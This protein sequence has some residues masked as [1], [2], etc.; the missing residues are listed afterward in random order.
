MPVQGVSSGKGRSRRSLL[1][2]LEDRVMLSVTLPDMTGVAAPASNPALPASFDVFVPPV[3][4]ATPSAS[5]PK[6]AQWTA[7]GNPDD[8]LA[9]SGKSLSALTGSS[10]GAD[11]QFYSYGQTTSSNGVLAADTIQSNDG[12]KAAVTLSMNN[13]PDSVYLLW[14]KNSYGYSSP[15]AINKATTWWVGPSQTSAG[16]TVSVYGQNLSHDGGTTS[17]WIYITQAGSSNGQWATVTSVNPYQVQFTV[18]SNLANGNYQVWVHN[19]EGGKYGWSSPVTM[20]VANAVVYAG[21]VINV[22]SYG[23]VGNGKTD[24]TA[25]INKALAAAMKTHNATVYLPAGTYIISSQL[26]VGEVDGSAIQLVGDGSAATILKCAS[27]FAKSSYTMLTA[28]SGNI[29]IADLSLDTSTIS[30]LNAAIYIRGTAGVQ[31]DSLVV[32]A[33]LSPYLDLNG[34]TNLV[35]SN[36]TFTGD[37]GFLGSASQVFITSCKFYGTNDANSL[38]ACWGGKQ[39]S[40]TYCTAADFDNSNPNSGAGWAEGRFLVGN[41]LWGGDTNIYLANNTT[42]GLGV[43]PTLK[44]QNQGEQILFE[45]QNL[46]LYPNAKFISATASTVKMSGLPSNF[47]PAGMSVTILNGNGVGESRTVTAYNASTR[48]LTLSSPWNVVPDS[49]SMVRV[50]TVVSQIAVYDNH[51][52]GKGNTHTA[53]TGVN[54][55]GGSVNCVVDSN[56]ISDVRN[57]V[58]VFALAQPNAVLPAYFDVIQNNILTNAETG[59]LLYGTSVAGGIGILGTQVRSN[60]ISNIVGSAVGII[61]SDNGNDLNTNIVINNVISNTAQTVGQT[62]SGAA[63]LN[64]YIDN[65]VNRVL[66]PSGQATTSTANTTPAGLQTVTA[67]VQNPVALSFH[68]R[69]R[70]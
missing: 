65:T 23:A 49:T 57:G 66:A 13:T 3:S 64:L 42:I 36:S 44:D 14:A 52:N 53:S 41:A 60:R 30:S 5:A 26:T 62:L 37:G 12:T 18:P 2:S 54:L 47:S 46:N 6:F 21:S 34:D 69:T 61:E 24:D 28:W 27:S 70:Q 15:V 9:I 68:R 33:H 50:G 43:R 55:Y 16:A 7:S 56:T 19:G 40:I 31:L 67:A 25:A 8:T 59:V 10:L 11:T 63:P 35:G 48:T 32:N 45:G 29:R 4:A 1:E 20:T 17:S 51:L 39:V 22:K 58:T 38:L